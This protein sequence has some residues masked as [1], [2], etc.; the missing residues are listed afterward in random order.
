M[1][2]LRAALVAVCLIGFVGYG[3]TLV[4]VTPAIAQAAAAGSEDSSS[5]TSKQWNSMKRKWAKEK[6]KWAD[7][8]KQAKEKGLKGR[9]SWGF[10]K[11]CMSK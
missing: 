8:R 11:D 4:H 3:A 2:G 5:W 7:C 1:H 9:K 6:E 10:L